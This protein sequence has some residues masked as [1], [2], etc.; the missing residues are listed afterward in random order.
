MVIN[1]KRQIHRDAGQPKFIVMLTI[2]VQD[3]GGSRRPGLLHLD[4][5]M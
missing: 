2:K 3:A 4:D 1:S 5:W